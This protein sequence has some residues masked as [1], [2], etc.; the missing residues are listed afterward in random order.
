MSDYFNDLKKTSFAGGLEGKKERT[1]DFATM[2]TK[3]KHEDVFAKLEIAVT[4]AIAYQKE[5]IK[6]DGRLGGQEQ[7]PNVVEIMKHV[8]FI[9]N[10]TYLSNGIE[11]II[12]IL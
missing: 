2:D 12:K 1:F 7:I 10:N 11:D 6:K 8:R 3:S 4:E 5:E 9:V